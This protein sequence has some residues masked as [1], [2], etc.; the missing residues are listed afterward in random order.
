MPRGDLLS[1]GKQPWHMGGS[2]GTATTAGDANQTNQNRW[3]VALI[4]WHAIQNNPAESLQVAGY[5]R[6]SGF[7]SSLAPSRSWKEWIG[8]GYKLISNLVLSEADE[9]EEETS[10]SL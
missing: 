6:A 2:S 8:R 7:C 4:P 9:H 10:L 3:E 1:S 5:C